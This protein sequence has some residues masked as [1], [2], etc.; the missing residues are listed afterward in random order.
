MSVTLHFEKRKL[1]VNLHGDI[2]RNDSLLL[3]GELLED[4]RLQHL[5]DLYAKSISFDTAY[6]AQ[7]PLTEAEVVPS[8]E[9]NGQQSGIRRPVNLDN[10]GADDE[11]TSRD[12]DVVSVPALKRALVN[13][14][15]H[16]DD[17]EGGS[18]IFPSSA[19]L[20][21]QVVVPIFIELEVGQSGTVSHRGAPQARASRAQR[22][23]S[24]QLKTACSSECLCGRRDDE[25]GAEL[26]EKAPTL[27]ASFVAVFPGL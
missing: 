14:C 25:A 6:R 7:R 5:L 4:I 24:R 13:L 9:D 21:T 3:K 22:L 11:K 20:A 18:E 12:V 1:F 17:I 10:H 26:E 23:V 15:G 2:V 19:R 16:G 27:L 8:A